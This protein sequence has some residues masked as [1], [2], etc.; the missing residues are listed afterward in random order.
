M[1]LALHPT[2]EIGQR[3]GRIL[4]A[5]AELEALG[6]YG[7]RGTGTEE[8][9]ATAI[10][11]LAG[12]AVLASD[13]GVAPLDL[14]GI[15]VADGLSCVLAA[16]IDSPPDL[17]GRFAARGL[18]LLVAASLPGLA[19]ALAHR[20]LGD[21]SLPGTLLLAWTR[22]GKP[23][24]RDV[25]VPFPDP[26]GARWG[27]RLPTRPGDPGSTTRAEALLDG[28]WAGALARLTAGTG[29]KRTE[30]LVAVADDR[31]H[32]EAVALAAGALLLARGGA[33]PGACRPGDVA[34]AYLAACLAVGLEVAGL[35]RAG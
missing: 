2:G 8:R 17:A 9:R 33:P 10:T 16:D 27:T 6:I 18:T 13:D 1:R 23:G 12:Y 24:R 22:P 3:A 7:H 34:P 4:L 28:P 31:R 14:A 15:A 5:E 21:G 29:R 25:A 32:L 19:E 11:S 35:G 30:R 26:V 20:A